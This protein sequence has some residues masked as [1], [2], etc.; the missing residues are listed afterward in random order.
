MAKMYIYIHLYICMYNTYIYVYQQ[1]NRR[2]AVTTQ[3]S[4]S[5]GGQRHQCLCISTLG[6]VLP[7]ASEQSSLGIIMSFLQMVKKDD[8]K[9]KQCALTHMVVA[10]LEF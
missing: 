10:E 9:M 8:T 3:I 2:R 6:R 7:A 1:Q 4:Q 5:P